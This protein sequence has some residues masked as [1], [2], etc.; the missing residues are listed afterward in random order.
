MEGNVHR[1]PVSECQISAS[2][3]AFLITLKRFC[4]RRNRRLN[5]YLSAHSTRAMTF[6][7]IRLSIFEFSRLSL[8]SERVFQQKA[9]GFKLKCEPAR[10]RYLP[11]DG[12]IIFGGSA[13]C[14]LAK[15]KIPKMLVR[16]SNQISEWVK[17]LAKNKA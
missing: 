8:S 17:E 16:S 7:S 6:V 5:H 13:K 9:V 2:D 12:H 14:F 1:V 10:L 3:A 4:V 11:V 15:K